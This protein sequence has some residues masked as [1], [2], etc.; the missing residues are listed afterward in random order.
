MYHLN[1]ALSEGSLLLNILQPVL[2][3]DGVQIKCRVYI[4]I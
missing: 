2:F 3:H 4:K 1:S